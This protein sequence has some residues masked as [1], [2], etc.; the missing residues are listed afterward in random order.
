MN[1]TK[2][3]TYKARG[4]VEVP[5]L[6]IIFN[7]EL[8]TIEEST[9]QSMCNLY[10]NEAEKIIDKMFKCLPEG[11]V[12]AIM[13]EILGKKRSLLAVPFIEPKKE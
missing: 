3:V 7:L 2:I 6:Q 12:D 4:G 5:S 10:K 1:E 11:L 8:P 13:V 9:P